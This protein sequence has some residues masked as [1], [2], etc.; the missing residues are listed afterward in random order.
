[1]KLEPKIVQHDSAEEI[2]GGYAY[3]DYDTNE[4]HILKPDSLYQRILEHERNHARQ[5]G[6]IRI[7]SYITGNST[8]QSALGVIL[9]SV[10]IGLFTIGLKPIIAGFPLTYTILLISGIISGT[11]LTL[12]LPAVTIPLEEFFAERYAIAKSKQP[13][14]DNP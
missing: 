7:L 11:V 10:A 8:I 6:P 2:D 12:I 9:L 14:A 1:M 3:Y 13:Q 5:T 4:I